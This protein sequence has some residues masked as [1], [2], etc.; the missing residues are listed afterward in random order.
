MKD[1]IPLRILYI[2]YG[3]PSL[4]GATSTITKII[5]NSR[6]HGMT[7]DVLEILP[8]GEEGLVS[9]FKEISDN[10]DEHIVIRLPFNRNILGKFYFYIY[11]SIMIKRILNEISPKY[12]FIMGAKHEKNIN[13][14]FS[15]PLIQLPLWKFYIKLARVSNPI[16]ALFWLR[17]AYSFY[18]Y[19]RISKRN[20]CAGVILRE[21]L[22]NEFGIQC[23]ALDPPGGVDEESLRKSSDITAEKFDVIHVARLGLVKG[24][25]DAIWVMDKLNR[26]G[27]ENNALI[28]PVDVGY[29]LEKEIVGRSIRYLGP[30]N[31][32][33]KL[34][35]LMRNAKL[36]LY[37]SKLDSFG[38]V[39]A[40]ALANGLPVVAYDI[41]A[42]R[43][44][45]GECKA[46]SL[47]PLDNREELLKEA[48]KS[49]EHRDELRDYATECGSLFSWD[50]TTK[51]FRDILDSFSAND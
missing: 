41:P 3:E 18:Q 23:H 16:E 26:L 6:K 14:L 47:A 19:S 34:Y 29:D 51:S 4:S 27:F 10:I 36:L 13:I 21:Q 31:D 5:G 35:S 45:F 11:K 33:S 40:E 9:K 1:V 15:I 44:Y 46:V 42:I 43:H 37:P 7:F 8:K 30:V 22:K 24:T 39:V 12:D 20:I 28:G 25:R 38:I 50:A 2:N 49:L 32:G 17:N 48:L